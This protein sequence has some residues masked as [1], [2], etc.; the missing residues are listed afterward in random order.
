MQENVIAV[1]LAGGKG[2]RLWPLTAKRAK[3]AVPIAG[4]YRL[5]DVSMSNALHS[6][7]H[8][9]VI[10][11]QF[12]S[13]SLHRHIH[14][15]YFYPHFS[16]GFAQILAAQQTLEHTNWYQGTADAVRQNLANLDQKG[17]EYYLILSGDHL[18]RM[19]YREL[20]KTH[21]ESGAEVTVSGY[22]IP[23]HMAPHFGILQI[24]SS[25][26]IISFHEKPQNPQMMTDFIPNSSWMR[27]KG[28][29]DQKGHLLAS[30]GIYVFSRKALFELLDECT[31]SDFGKEIFPYA[32]GKRLVVAHPFR[33]YWEDIGTIE[34]FFNAMIALTDPEPK[35][36]FYDENYPIY[37]HP[38]PLPGTRLYDC[39][40]EDSIVCD[41][42]M[43]YQA[44]I[45]KSIIGI[46]S[47]VREGAKLAHV[48]LMGADYW[49]DEEDAEANRA[50]QR[51]PLGIGEN[52]IIEKAIIDKNARIGR[53][54]KLLQANRPEEAVAENYAIRNGI[55]I[56]PKGA[57]IQDGF[58]I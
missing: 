18:Y 35:F 4:K 32:I 57:V 2:T 25:G 19:D 49:E 23:P 42:G 34:A 10:L 29:Q 46:R 26:R 54:V 55:L 14:Q 22:L 36:R 20:L 28:F 7:V 50:A 15:T 13:E 31:G 6:G 44:S 58:T 3:P 30:M 12:A 52:S 39:H 43:L 24:D 17:I 1:I 5:I 41:G 33:G 48:V 45:L 21:I 47:F 8:K 40:V 11:T 38:R 16:R 27:E 9:I 37:T 56:V 53:E 51:P